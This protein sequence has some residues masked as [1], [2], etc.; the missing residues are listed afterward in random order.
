MRSSTRW[1]MGCGRSSR[2]RRHRAAGC[3]QRRQWG[4]RIGRR[5]LLT[6]LRHFGCVTSPRVIR[7]GL[8]SFPQP[9]LSGQRRNTDGRAP[10]H[11]AG[12]CSD[13]RSQWHGSRRPSQD[14]LPR[15]SPCTERPLRTPWAEARKSSA[16]PAMGT[17]PSSRCPSG[18]R[19]FARRPRASRE[20]L[21]SRGC[22]RLQ[23]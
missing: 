18:G 1:I 21:Y 7:A 2:R 17:P 6:G 15:R 19:G 8:A 9:S 12:C 20:L 16:F 23:A 22:S 10:L 11:A 4:R 13:R 5:G 14:P 3:L